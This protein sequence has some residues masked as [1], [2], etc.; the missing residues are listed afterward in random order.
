MS[1]EVL[2]LVCS[3]FGHI[4]GHPIQLHRQ[5]DMH[6]NM[7]KELPKAKTANVWSNCGDYKSVDVHHA[8]YSASGSSGALQT[9]GCLGQTNPLHMSC[10]IKAHHCHPGHRYQHIQ[11]V[12]LAVDFLGKVA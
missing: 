11:L 2:I 8:T 6:P 9:T 5:L 1:S 4:C 3:R 10:T 12:L 7:L